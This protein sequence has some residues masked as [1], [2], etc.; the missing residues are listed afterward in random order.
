MKPSE[1]LKLVATV[2]AMVAVLAVSAV[3]RGNIDAVDAPVAAEA[4]YEESANCSPWS[5]V[6]T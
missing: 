6:K 5:L 1:L 3:A 4:S 2:A